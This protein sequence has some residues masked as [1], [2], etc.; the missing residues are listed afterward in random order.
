[1]DSTL[2]IQGLMIGSIILFTAFSIFCGFAQNLTM[3]IIGRTGQGLSGGFLLPIVMLVIADRL[4][5][6]QQPAGFA[7]FG[8]TAVTGPVIGPL[9]GGWLTESASWHYAFFINV[10]IGLLLF[11]LV[12]LA[13]VAIAIAGL[14][15]AVQAKSQPQQSSMLRN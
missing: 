15:I 4:P 2:L 5:L 11:G 1:M 9:F 10:P 12:F 14:V 3:M 8:T 13:T 6:R 7:M